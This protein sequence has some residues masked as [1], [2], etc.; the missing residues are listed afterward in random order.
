MI[1]MI[2]LTCILSFICGF[3][4]GGKKGACVISANEKKRRAEIQKLKEEF[5]NFL[6][7]DGS[8]QL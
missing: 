4:I 2:F 1:I 7:Y 8:E 6:E 5:K 3:F